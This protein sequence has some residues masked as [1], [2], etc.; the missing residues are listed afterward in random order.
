MKTSAFLTALRANPD[1]PLVFQAGSETAAPGYH[2]TEV[3]RVGYETMDCGAMTH[4]WSE[5][6]FEIWAPST[7]AAAPGRSHMP[8]GKFLRIIDRVAAGVALD[9]DATARIHASFQGQPAAL[10]DIDGL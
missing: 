10:Y 9:G 6:Q 7:N 2:L 3:K 1:L 5:S 4:R 8:A